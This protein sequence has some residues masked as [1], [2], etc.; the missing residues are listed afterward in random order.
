MLANTYVPLAKC[1]CTCYNELISHAA[2][3]MGS[4]KV[5][6]DVHLQHYR[7]TL[8]MSV[9]GDFDPRQVNYAKVFDLQEGEDVEAYIENLDTIEH[10]TNSDC[11][12]NW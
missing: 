12:P 6:D 10:I 8:D 1:V 7:V 5:Y 3:I 11:C 9:L 2:T 4:N